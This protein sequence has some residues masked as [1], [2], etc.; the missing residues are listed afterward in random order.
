[1][2]QKLNKSVVPIYTKGDKTDFSNYW[3]ML[4]LSNRHKM[5]LNILHRQ[6]TLLGSSVCIRLSRSST[7]HTFCIRQILEKK[8]EYN[9]AVHQLLI[10][11]KKAFGSVWR[12]ALPLS[13]VSI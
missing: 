12:E 11:L 1:L 13:F 2:L 5:L 6:R 4:L 7:D 3:G 10:D 8:L 9:G